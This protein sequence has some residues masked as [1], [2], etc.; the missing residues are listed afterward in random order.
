M[1]ILIKKNDIVN[2][3]SNAYH[4]TIKMKAIEWMDIMN[5]YQNLRKVLE[6]FILQIGVKKFLWIKTLYHTTYVM[7][8]LNGDEIVELQQIN[9]T[10]FRA[11]KVI[12][13]KYNKL[14]VKWKNY[15]N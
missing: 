1:C 14:C 6:R 11:K 9:Q 10:E 5:G 3:Y 2:E 12:K 4:R 8:E 15:D 7:E 13:K